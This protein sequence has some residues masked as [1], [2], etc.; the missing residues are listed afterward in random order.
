MFFVRLFLI[1]LVIC[2]TIKILSLVTRYLRS[3][4][5]Q[6][7]IRAEENSAGINEMVRDPVCGL[8]IPS[9]GAVGLV[10]KGKTIYFCSEKCRQRFVNNQG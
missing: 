1:V 4:F 9:D 6:T 7:R 5:E 3:Q 8:Y 10:N 2:L